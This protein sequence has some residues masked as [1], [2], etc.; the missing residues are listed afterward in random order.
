MRHARSGGFTL[1]ELMVALAVAAV[2]LTLGLPSFQAS[3]RSNRLATANN[4]L[5]ASIAMA[6]SEAMRSNRGAGICATGD[7]A[8]CGADWNAGWLVWG[9]DNRNGA[10]DAGEVVT[11]H[12]QGHPALNL[13]TESGV[14][15]IAF[16]ARG[17]ANAVQD[18]VMRPTTCPTGLE[19]VNR[20]K[21]NGSGQVTTTKETCE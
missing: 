17:T 15:S 21:M 6:R 11:R 2:L 5:I 8:S 12:V 14:T 19:L 16:S 20:L 1:I 7:G 13:V 4:E 9:D 18:F 3:L 10:L